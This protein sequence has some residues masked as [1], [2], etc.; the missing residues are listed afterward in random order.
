MVILVLA[1]CVSR[2]RDARLALFACCWIVLPIIPV[3]FLRAYAEGDIA[4]DR[5]LYIPSIGFVLLMALLLAEVARRWPPIQ[6]RLQLGMLVIMAVVYAPATLAQQTYWASDLLLYGRAY[7]I[8]PRDSLICNDLGAALMDAGKAG[9]AL[10]LYSQVVARE[11]GFWL[12]NY[13]LGYTY[14]KIGKLPEA[15]LYLRRAISINTADSDEYIY[16]GLSVWRQGRADE[17][18]QCVQRAIQIRPSAPGYHFA[19]AMIL[20]EQNNIAAAEDELKQEL[21]YNPQSVAAQQQLDALTSGA[22]GSK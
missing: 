15:E 3:L 16:L 11:P 2:L 22:A 6:E 4:H 17:A 9:D 14:Y 21:F 10:A 1:W 19:L 12:S 8:A 13:N 20:R 18:V 7:S 5:Y